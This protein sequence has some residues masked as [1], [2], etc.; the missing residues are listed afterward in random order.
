MRRVALT[1]LLIA[2]T[3]SGCA[4]RT[5]EELAA[6]AL[7]EHQ[8]VIAAA[9]QRDSQAYAAA[10][11]RMRPTIQRLLRELDQS[12]PGVS[13]SVRN[14]FLRLDV[15]SQTPTPD[16]ETVVREA[17]LLRSALTAV[18]QRP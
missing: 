3:L 7:R 1:L 12:A 13:A 2:A 6:Q 14:P 16:W 11:N 18:A 9:T 10:L 5:A 15:A 8:K 4:A 17:A